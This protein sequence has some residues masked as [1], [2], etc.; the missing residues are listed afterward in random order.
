MCNKFKRQH[1]CILGIVA[2]ICLP[3]VID[4]DIIG[5]S[6][7]DYILE[8]VIADLKFLNTGES[9]YAFVTTSHGWTLFHPRMPSKTFAP[10]H[11]KF[12]ESLETVQPVIDDM[13]RYK[14]YSVKYMFYCSSSLHLLWQL[15]ILGGVLI[16]TFHSFETG[17]F[18]DKIPEVYC[19]RLFHAK[20][21][22]IVRTVNKVH[23]YT[24][25]TR[26]CK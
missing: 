5:I 12:L 22:N 19:R 8:D 24:I 17:H 13:L 26:T 23:M 15:M 14:W 7:I 1:I 3:V 18:D 11:I 2:S 6:C 25:D 16:I 9:S 10:I 21:L 4:G 20:Q